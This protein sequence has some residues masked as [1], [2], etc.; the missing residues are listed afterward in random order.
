MWFNQNPLEVAAIRD[1]I[2]TVQVL[3]A[4][5][6]DVDFRNGR[7]GRTALFAAAAGGY[8]DMTGL[9]LDDGASCHIVDAE[10][11]TPLDVALE[12]KFLPRAGQVQ[13]ARLLSA[14]LFEQSELGQQAPNLGNRRRR[15]C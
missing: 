12:A 2:D 3:L 15:S 14:K 7:N 5:G 6:V 8:V 10:G 9:L 13:T 1:H 4:A 11:K